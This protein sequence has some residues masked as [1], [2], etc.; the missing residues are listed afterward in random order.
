VQEL[1]TVPS[2]RLVRVDI[3]EAHGTDH[4]RTFQMTDA[5]VLAKHHALSRLDLYATL[6]AA[7]ELCHGRFGVPASSL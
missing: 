5:A 2:D 1:V 7:R 4:L 3:T 6:K